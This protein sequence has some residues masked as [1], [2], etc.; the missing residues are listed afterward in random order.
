MLAL[1]A[2]RVEL[3]LFPTMDSAPSGMLC[4]KPE[5]QYDSH[6]RYKMPPLE[7]RADQRSKQRKTYL[8]NAATVARSVFRPEAYLVKY[9]AWRLSTDCGTSSSGSDAYLTGHHAADQLQ[10]LT[11]SFIR[12]YVLCKCG[13]PETFLFVEGKKKNRVAKLKCHSCGRAGNAAGQDDKMLN[14]ITALPMPPELCPM[15]MISR[16]QAH[17]MASDLN[18]LTSCLP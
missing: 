16:E 3:N 13:S 1:R 2:L 6:Y 18:P 5:R 9:Y 8:S 10:E 17:K 12:E 4:L 7:V 14:L 11:F 15:G